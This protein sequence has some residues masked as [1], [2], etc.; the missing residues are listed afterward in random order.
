MTTE[1]SKRRGVQSVP[2]RQTSI[3]EK[4]ADRVEQVFASL[5]CLPYLGEAERLDYAHYRKLFKELFA[6]I[7]RKREGGAD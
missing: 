4:A 1:E 6:R 7:A 5:D 2:N 3:V